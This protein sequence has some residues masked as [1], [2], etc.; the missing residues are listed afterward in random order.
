MVHQMTAIPVLKTKERYGAGLVEIV[1]WRVP[2]PVPASE[3]PFKYRLVYVVD[4]RRIV[5]DDNERGKG[6]HRHLG[7]R[8]EGYRFI[9]P[10]RL[11]TD[12][13]NDVRG[14]AA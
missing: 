11:L 3:H 6:D 12:F 10:D 13:W 1:I 2:E 8:E 7:E 14:A 5:G 9:D 4:G